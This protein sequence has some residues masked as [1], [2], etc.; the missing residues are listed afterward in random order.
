MP[1]NTSSSAESVHDHQFTGGATAMRALY[2]SSAGPNPPTA[3]ATNGTTIQRPIT[4]TPS[5]ATSVT[6]TAHRPPVVVYATTIVAA[7]TI[8]QV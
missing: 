1:P 5:C 4:S 8:D 7:S 6:A 3:S 2:W